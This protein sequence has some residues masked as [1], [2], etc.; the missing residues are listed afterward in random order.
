MGER[1]NGF[2][3]TRRHRRWPTVIAVLIGVVILGLPS[4][5]VAA[6]ISDDFTGDLV[7]AVLGLLCYGIIDAVATAVWRRTNR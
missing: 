5:L 1:D 4:V 6:L 7:A 3:Q 2:A